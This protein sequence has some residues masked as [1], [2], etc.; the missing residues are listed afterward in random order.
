ME[1]DWGPSERPEGGGSSTLSPWDSSQLRSG[2]CFTS[3]RSR[4]LRKPPQNGTGLLRKVFQTSFISIAATPTT[5]PILARPAGG[6]PLPWL[7]GNQ[8]LSV[9]VLQHTKN[10]V[11]NALELF[12][13]FVGKVQHPREPTGLKTTG[14]MKLG[15]MVSLYS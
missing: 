15:E 1:M 10:A 4:P 7:D 14:G 3:K 5:P 11:A 13:A 12:T 8:L 9:Y 6:D 2:S